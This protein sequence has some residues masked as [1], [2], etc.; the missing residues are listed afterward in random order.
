MLK[1]IEDALH[2]R[3]L[4]G[5]ATSGQR[6][7][8][9]LGERT[10]SYEELH[11]LALQWAG[12]LLASPAG[13]PAAIGVLAAKGLEAY[14]GIL[15]GLY[16]GATVVPLHPAFPA[17]RTRSMLQDAGVSAV[18]ADDAGLAALEQALGD[19]DGVGLPV[20]APF[21]ARGAGTARRLQA[22]P[23]DALREPRPVAPGDRA[24]ILF[25]S[26][27][28]GRP[29]GVPIAH[30]STTHY[31]R[32]IDERYRFDADDVFSQT[33][34]VNFDCAMFDMFSAWGAGGAVHPVPLQ[35]YRDLPAFVA[36]RRMTV[37]FSTPSTISLLRRTGSLAPGALPGLRWSLFAGEAL[38]DQD[39]ADWQAAAPASTL[40]N[41]YGP[42]E[43]TVTVT[44]HRW[45]PRTS[46]A[47]CVNGLV[48]IG[49]V[50]EGH[51]H[52]LLDQDG[53]PTDAE[54][55]LLITGPQMT[56]GYLDPEHDRGRFLQH[57]GRTWYR[58]GDRVRRLAG[59][60]LVYLGRLDAQ[61]QIQGWRVEL[62]EVE[63]AVRTCPSVQDA[64]AVARTG[65][66][67]TELVVFYTGRPTPA[68]ALAAALRALL[69]QG[70][71]PKHYRHVEDFPLNSNRKVDRKA[72]R[73]QA[74]VLPAPS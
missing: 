3:F 67:G 17:A 51:E 68:A 57:E 47:L 4:R 23:R 60:E 38:R 71:V 59:G 63:H 28:T 44:G 11:E 22:A 42:T 5:L 46:P 33:F 6:P 18:L 9:H 15:A 30:G 43:L 21:A 29:K 49:T 34:D 24:Y 7:A 61:V 32:L 62:A 39:A 19:G 10:V 45:S 64:V 26:G 48:P 16:T 20:L 52:L 74:A 53:R 31:F 58:T 54:G 50:H 65:D 35:A 1:T 70:M 73:E 37:W 36:E 66:A 56:S 14:A 40:E 25:T 27:S 8:L 2:A 69:P 72:L 12:T 55:E 41:I 13:P